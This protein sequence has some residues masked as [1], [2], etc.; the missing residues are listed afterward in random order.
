MRLVMGVLLSLL[1]GVGAA[2]FA[3]EKKVDT[4]KTEKPAEAKAEAK[5]E[6]KPEI[7]MAAADPEAMVVKINNTVI[8]EKTV[9][10]E[11]AKRLEVQKKR[12]PQ[13]ME[14][15]DWMR[16]QVRSSVVEMLVERELLNQKLAEKKLDVTDE[17]VMKEIETIAAAQN[18]TMEQVPAE[19]EKFGM[20]M[21]DLKSQIR[22]KVQMDKLV[23]AEMKD[24]KVTDEDVKK[25]YDDN[26]QYFEKPEQVQ[27]S[28]ILVK[29]EKD[30]S[31]ADKAAAKTKIEGLLK[32]V[33]EGGDFAELAKANSDCPS[34]ERGGD[35]GM[36]GR[37]QMVKE[38]EDAAFGMEV[39]QISDIVETQFGYHIIKKTGAAAAKK[40]AMEDVAPR[41]RQHL[42]QQ[43]RN[44]FWQTYNKQLHDEAK[45]EYSESEKALR[46]QNAQPRMPMPPAQPAQS[47]HQHDENCQH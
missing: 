38:F 26:P 34:K 42:E 28:H 32:Q 14:I 5:T 9:A 7:K 25:F 31:D 30:A 11:T 45:I 35:L 24:G 43:K 23:A 18:L 20:T 19:I 36:F 8:K 15:N 37:G 41:I 21:D 22:M 10:D 2:A 4:K 46:E 29:V 33:K 1:M 40:D 17:D 27:A 39:G 47:E 13:G 6:V 3:A 12:M 16:N 44:E